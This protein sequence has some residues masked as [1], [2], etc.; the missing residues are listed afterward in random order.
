MSTLGARIR[1]M[2]MRKGYE[3][4]KLAYL[5]GMSSELLARLERDERIDLTIEDMILLAQTLD[6]DLHYILIGDQKSEEEADESQEILIDEHSFLR[7]VINEDILEYMGHYPITFWANLFRKMCKNE[8]SPDGMC[9]L[10]DAVE[11]VKPSDDNSSN[12]TGSNRSRQ[13]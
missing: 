2:R 8:I 9:K 6:A 10:I 13:R 1:K 3:L 12:G 11:T 7:Q 4:D 5:T